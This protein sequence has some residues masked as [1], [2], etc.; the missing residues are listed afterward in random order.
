MRLLLVADSHG[1]EMGSVIRG[2]NK[3]WT[4]LT[5]R[6]SSQTAAVRERY[7]QR[8]S[9]I[10][11]FEPEAIVLHVGHNDISHHAYYNPDPKHVKDFFPAIL[12]F[13]GLLQGNHPSARVFYSSVFPRSTG[14]NMNDKNRHSYNKLASRFGAL[15]QST[16]MREGIS[17]NI[18]PWCV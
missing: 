14:P 11:Q 12:E 3:E 2:I 15:T 8:L 16:C 17:L 7:L 4:V 10:R 6:V 9:E 1:R 5:V 18:L 13:V